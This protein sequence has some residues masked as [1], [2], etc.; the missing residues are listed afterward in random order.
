MDDFQAVE[1]RREGA[2]ANV[3]AAR[4]GG[5]AVALKVSPVRQT[6]PHDALNEIEVLAAVAGDRVVA[7]LDAVLDQARGQV[8]LVMPLYEASLADA[9]DRGVAADDVRTITR[10][11]TGALA[12]VHARGVI[13]RDV[14]PGNVLLAGGRAVLADF[15][16]A[17]PNL[18]APD[19]EPADA[20]ITDV[21][22]SVY[23]A[24]EL[25]FAY[26]AY[27]DRIDVWSWACVVAEMLTGRPLFGEPTTSEIGLAN[28]IFRTLGTP[29]LATWPEAAAF[30]S[31]AHIRFVPHAPRPLAEVLPVAADAR[32][33][34]ARMLVYESGRRASA[35]EL[36]ADPYV[37]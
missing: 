22:T 7:V 37:A 20:K 28:A 32:A 33:F 4:A 9:I 35:R 5:R 17:W 11:I 16:T 3:Y 12:H 23:R 31:F 18:A 36:L 13:H 10:D 8:V 30:A 2:C 34:V 29:D 6:P 1:F 21:S 19:A 26:G 27:S 24:P 15:G 25:L 14:K